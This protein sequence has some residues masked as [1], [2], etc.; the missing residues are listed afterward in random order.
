MNN[1][2]LGTLLLLFLA[3][4]GGLHDGKGWE[5]DMDKESQNILEH[6]H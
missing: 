6:K 5:H 2:I 3:S 1:F 4:C